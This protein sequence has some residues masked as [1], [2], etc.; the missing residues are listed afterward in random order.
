VETLLHSLRDYTETDPKLVLDG[1]HAVVSSFVENFDSF[2]RPGYCE[3]LESSADRIVEYAN[4]IR[5]SVNPADLDK[6]AN[7][8]M[9]W[10]G[11]GCPY[12]YGVLDG[13]NMKESAKIIR[14]GPVSEPKGGDKK[15]ASV[16]KGADKSKVCA[17]P[18]TAAT[19][20]SADECEQGE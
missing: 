17:S 11:V 10:Q 1:C 9:D 2:N 7:V 19:E 13:Y 12:T 8:M 5:N 3:D 14:Q 20:P 16:A 4:R 18:D 6:L 15:P